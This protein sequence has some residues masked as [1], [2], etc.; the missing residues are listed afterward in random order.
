MNSQIAVAGKKAQ[1]FILPVWKRAEGTRYE[2]RTLSGERK[3][4]RVLED[5]KHCIQTLQE[6]KRVKEVE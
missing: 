3:T 5:I 6:D 2:L 4:F 1:T